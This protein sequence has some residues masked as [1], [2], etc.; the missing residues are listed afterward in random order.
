MKQILLS[1]GL[2]LGVTVSAQDCSDLFISEYIEGWSNN[3]ALE[4]Y[5]LDNDISE[6]NDIAADNPKVVARIENFLKTARTESP[7]W[8]N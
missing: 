3:K 6:S 2:L 1:L 7:H 4:L 8:P 5:N